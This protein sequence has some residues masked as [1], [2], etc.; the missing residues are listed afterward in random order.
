MIDVPLNAA[1]LCTDGRCGSSTRFILDP[2]TRRVVDVVVRGPAP[3]RTEHVVPVA[4]VVAST[5]DTIELDCPRADFARMQPFTTTR[6]VPSEAPELDADTAPLLYDAVLAMRPARVPV[7]VERVPEGDLVVKNGMRVAATDGSVG[8]VGELLADPLTGTITHF[9]LR[10]GHLLDRRELTLPVSAVK[11]ADDDT[12]YLTLDKAAIAQLPAIPVGRRTDRAT[13]RPEAVDLLAL[14]FDA[15]D[16]AEQALQALRRAESI[17]AIAVRNAAVLRK[18]AD[19]KV[20][21]TEVQQVAAERGAGA[22]AILG[23]IIGLLGG[24]AGVLVGAAV[25]AGTGGLAAALVAAGF[26]RRDLEGLERAMRPNS[27]AVV[28]LIEH[29]WVEAAMGALGQFGGTVLRQ[30][31]TDEMVDQFNAAR[32]TAAM[33]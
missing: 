19:G 9:T 28:A 30:A 2:E 23:A 8:Q 24:P 4:H 1:V 7:T 31:V 12:L 32:R 33:S 21:V 3:S 14:V 27:S 16:T 11:Q 29:R 10:E 26:A 17:G 22:G 5:A 25:G 20:K 15:P 18:D 13:G 6:Y